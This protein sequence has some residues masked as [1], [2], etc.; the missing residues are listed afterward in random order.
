LAKGSAKKP[1]DPKC[2]AC[3]GLL[4]GRPT[5]IIGGGKWHVECAEKQ[6]KFIPVE[7]REGYVRKSQPEVAPAEAAAEQAAP[8]ES[9][10]P[11]AEESAAE[12][13]AEEAEETAVVE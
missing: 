8:A 13:A 6:G 10:A 2:R 7:Y 9:E 12:E 4:E 11:V 5:A 3:S 1:G